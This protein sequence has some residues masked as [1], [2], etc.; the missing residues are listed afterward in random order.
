MTATGTFYYA[1][2]ARP[3]RMLGM[4]VDITDR[5]LIEEALKKSEEKF[6]KAFRESPMA[7]T[8]TSAVDQHYLDINGTFELITGW[9]R[10]EVIGRTP[11][12]IR[13][14]GNPE[15]RIELV[16]RLTL[17]AQFGIRKL[18]SVA[19]TVLRDLA[20]PRRS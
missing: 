9:R 15:D 18:V 2:S 19:R 13:I 20:S 10:D 16:K 4:A 1:K 17:K 12:D 6:S 14:W 8:L 11:F 7:L 5:R 3:E